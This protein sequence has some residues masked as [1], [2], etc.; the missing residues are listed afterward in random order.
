MILVGDIYSDM[1]EPIN[2]EI[3]KFGM[4]EPDFAATIP[5]KNLRILN[6]LEVLLKLL[7]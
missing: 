2:K 6:L 5:I 4:M 3:N 7:L 1:L